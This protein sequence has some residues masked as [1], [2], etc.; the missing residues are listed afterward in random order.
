MSVSN[1]SCSV[2]SARGK[3]VHRDWLETRGALNPHWGWTGVLLCLVLTDSEGTRR[4]EA[5]CYQVASRNFGTTDDYQVKAWTAGICGREKKGRITNKE[6]RHAGLQELVHLFKESLGGIT[7]RIEFL[8]L[9]CLCGRGVQWAPLSP[10]TCV[11][12]GV[13]QNSSTSHSGYVC[14]NWEEMKKKKEGKSKTGQ[15]AAS[16]FKYRGPIHKASSWT[17]RL[18]ICSGGGHSIIAGGK[19]KQIGPDSDQSNYSVPFHDVERQTRNSVHLAGSRL[20]TE[21]VTCV[22]LRFAKGLSN[23]QFW[24]AGHTEDKC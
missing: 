2:P 24:L 13:F 4:N 15:N 16:W 5:T 22:S 1:C 3:R 7:K 12:P 23:Q 18:F 11:P 8:S 10:S 20:H 19:K 14:T 6:E 17:L 9:R 21:D